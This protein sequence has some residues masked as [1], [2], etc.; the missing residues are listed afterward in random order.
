MAI[1]EVKVGYEEL[2]EV[3]NE[4]KPEQV[5]KISLLRDEVLREVSLTF[6]IGEPTACVLTAKSKLDAQTEQR[7]KQWFYGS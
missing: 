6:A 7:Q 5:V 1:D 2:L 3:V 4:F